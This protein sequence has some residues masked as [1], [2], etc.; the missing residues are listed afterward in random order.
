MPIELRILSGS[1][2]GQT[3]SFDKSVVAIGR[4][5]LSDLRFDPN[6]DIDVSTRHGEIRVLDNQYVI[7]DNESTNGTFVNGQRLPRGGRRARQIDA[8]SRHIE[9]RSTWVH[10]CSIRRAGC[11]FPGAR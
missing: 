6:I 1:R 3:Q 9:D 7:I 4:H 2:A 10:G 5:P 8:G 11:L